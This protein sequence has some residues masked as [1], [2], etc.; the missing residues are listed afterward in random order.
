[1]TQDTKV[2]TLKT[3]VETLA[4]KAKST[5]SSHEAMQ[6]AQAALNL[7]HAVVMLHD[8]HDLDVPRT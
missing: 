4:V 6:Y 8:L 7:T 5:T 1:M 2:E 3:A